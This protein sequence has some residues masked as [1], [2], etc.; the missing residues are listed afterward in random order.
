MK[1]VNKSS[2]LKVETTS[3]KIPLNLCMTRIAAMQQR[4][5]EERLAFE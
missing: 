4:D 3:G 1:H 5:N 2:V